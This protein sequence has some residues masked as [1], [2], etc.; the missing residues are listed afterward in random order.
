[1]RIPFLS[2]ATESKPDEINLLAPDLWDGVSDGVQS[3]LLRQAEMMVKATVTVATGTDS[4][5]ITTMSVL[6]AGGIALLAAAASLIGNKPPDWLLICA[7]TACAAGLLVA[8]II[9][10][11]AIAPT[12]FLLP[13]ASPE[14]ILSA[15]ITDKR[16]LRGDEHRL[17][18]ALIYSSQRAI[19]HNMNRAIASTARFE[20]ALFIA[21]ASIMAGAG[22]IAF[23]MANRLPGSF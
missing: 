19:K 5:I 6:G 22:F 16:R 11:F 1:M 23:W 17:R 15:D 13:G 21:G 12:L 2:V 20:L 9:C 4:R 8:A 3:E 18:A 10:A 14:S 7:P